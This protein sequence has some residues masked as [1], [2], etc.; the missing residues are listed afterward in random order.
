MNSQIILV[1]GGSSTVGLAAALATLSAHGR[2]VM[3]FD[4]DC[5]SPVELTAE[6]L[7]L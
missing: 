1:L 2:T 4:M 3:V 7:M 5:A 6:Q